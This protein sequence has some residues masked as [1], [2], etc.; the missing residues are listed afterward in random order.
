MSNA[1][2]KTQLVALLTAAKVLV[3][4]IQSQTEG[5]YTSADFQRI[6]EVRAV[7]EDPPVFTVY[8]MEEL[9]NLLV[10]MYHAE[11]RTMEELDLINQPP[12]S[13]YTH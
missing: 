10:D 2:T 6:E 7:L 3:D 13:P 9:M 8:D 1:L 4:A 11:G 5:A 12:S